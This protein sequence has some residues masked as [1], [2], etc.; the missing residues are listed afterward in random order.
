MPPNPSE[1]PRHRS[2][3]YPAFSLKTALDKVNLIYHAHKRSPLDSDTLKRV[4]GYEVTT[5]HS[6]RAISALIQ[7][8]LI[9]EEGSTSD[10][11]L[12]LSDLGLNIVLRNETDPERVDL[13]RKAAT[14]PVVYHEMFELW[15]DGLPSDDAIS[16]Y[17]LFTKN[18][19]PAVVPGVVRDFK[20]TYAY[21][22]FPSSDVQIGGE[23]KKASGVSRTA[24]ARG[25]SPMPI[26]EGSVAG[27]LPATSPSPALP[28]DVQ[29]YRLPLPRG[30]QA[31]IEVP[32]NASATDI[33]FVVRYLLLMRDA[34]TEGTEPVEK[35]GVQP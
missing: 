35:E 12:K 8:N 11:R 25:E 31:A 1:S 13:L 7:F 32:A 22:Q 24:S 14:H 16:N 26:L 3:A 28:A 20:A 21:A 33:D 30:R 17:L 15:N 10:R 27:I 29:R 4:M 2:P 19:N 9:A 34:L 18:F 23:S 6:M 5:S